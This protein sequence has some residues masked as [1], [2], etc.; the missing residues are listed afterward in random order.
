[1]WQSWRF[2]PQRLKERKEVKE[3]RSAEALSAKR[4]SKC[5]PDLPLAR[6]P[7][8]SRLLRFFAFLR[9]ILDIAS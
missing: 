2:L 3:G 8:E 9:Q 6:L 4:R 7:L 1:M 5:L